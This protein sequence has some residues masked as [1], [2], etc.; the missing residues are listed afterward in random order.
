MRA[1]KYPVPSYLVATT[2]QADYDAWL[3]NKSANLLRKDKRRNRPCGRNATLSMYK[4][5]IHRAVCNGNGLDPYTGDTLRFDQIHQWNSETDKG[6]PPS[7]TSK[8]RGGFEKQFYL[9]PTVDHKD[10]LSDV[11][12]FEICSWLINSCKSDQ[13][14]KEFIAMCGKVAERAQDLD[15]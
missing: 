5:G 11:I 10:P 6:R 1:L 9:L 15:R 2:S 4:A 13:T 14:P 7:G 3:N 12:D 8:G